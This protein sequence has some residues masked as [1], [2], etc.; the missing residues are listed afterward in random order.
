M[1]HPAET[2]DRA[3]KPYQSCSVVDGIFE[4]DGFTG[5]LSFVF[6]ANVFRVHIP[7]IVVARITFFMGTLPHILI[8]E[9]ESVLWTMPPTRKSDK[10]CIYMTPVS[11][12]PSSYLDETNRLA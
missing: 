10:R 2:R 3:S 9:L 4:K 1:A 7:I 8:K 11:F 12:R 5:K 6:L